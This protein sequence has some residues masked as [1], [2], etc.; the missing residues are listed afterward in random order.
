LPGIG[1]LL[2]L[3]APAPAKHRASR[4]TAAITWL[5]QLDQFSLYMAFLN[6]DRS[7]EQLVTRYAV[8]NK[9]CPAVFL[10]TDPVAA[11]GQGIYLQHAVQ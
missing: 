5:N 8:R 10:A 3:A 9:D 11:I 1:Q 6:L 2:P 7:P 4:L